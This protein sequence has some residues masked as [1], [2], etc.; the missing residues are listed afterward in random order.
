MKL[1]STKRTSNEIIV[2]IYFVIKLSYKVTFQNSF[3]LKK[4]SNIKKFPKADS[5]GNPNMN[6]KII[7]SQEEL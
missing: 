5:L 2:I 1:F 7:I 6:Q 4:L 3:I